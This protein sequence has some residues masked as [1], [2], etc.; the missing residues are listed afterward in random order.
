[1]TESRRLIV[2]A[3][4]FGQSLGINHGIVEA[5]ERG[6]VTSASLM[7]RWPGA[8]DAASYARSHTKLSVGLHLD[9]GEWKCR[10]GEWSP[11]YEVVSRHDAEAVGHEIDRQIQAFRALTGR[12]PTHVD[13]HQHVHRVEPVRSLLVERARAIGVPLR[14]FSGVN[15]CGSF[16][17]Q[18]EEGSPLPH[19]I[20]FEAL[21]SL[22]E[23]LPAGVTE[24]GCHPGREIDFE[25]MY[26]GERLRELEVLCDTRIRELAGR[27]HIQLCSFEDLAGGTSTEATPG[28]RP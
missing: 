9:L 8:E 25:T 5:Y 7:V 12:L 11:L 23:D 21:S 4:D 15:Y 28:L 18:T 1:M 22:L 10:G 20:S 14:L 19:L 24:L 3:D 16:Y 13:S 6:I 17:G 27:K 2:N 26:A